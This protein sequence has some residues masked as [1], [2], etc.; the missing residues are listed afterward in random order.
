MFEHVRY[1]IAVET[2]CRWKIWEWKLFVLRLHV[3][4]DVYDLKFT[5]MVDYSF[6][7]S[8]IIFVIISVCM[9]GVSTSTI[10]TRAFWITAELLNIEWK[11]GCLTTAGCA[12]PR[13]KLIKTNSVTDQKLSISWSVSEKLLEVCF[14]F[15]LLLPSLND[16]VV[17]RNDSTDRTKR[18]NEN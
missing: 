11:N 8:A 18:K 1:C 17:G 2:I 14:F 7:Y 6:L 9:V 12:E 5:T 4:S 13:F 15:F 3:C 16:V 10:E